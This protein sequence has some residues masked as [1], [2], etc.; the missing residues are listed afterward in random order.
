MRAISLMILVLA[1]SMS[2]LSLGQGTTNATEPQYQLRAGDTLMLDFRLSPELNQTVIVDRDGSISLQIIGRV[3]VSGLTLDRA[4]ALILEKESTHLVRPE[5]NLSLTDF[6]HFYVVVAGEVY[7]P[8]K[9]EI[10]E[11]MTALQAIMLSGGVKNTGSQTQVLLYRKVNSE[12]AEVHP[13]NLRIRKTVELEH[14]MPLMPGDL[15][16]VRRSKVESVTRYTRI[17]GLNYN[18]VPQAY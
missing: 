15:I 11:D 9:L 3:Q 5:L 13:L 17:V 10:R 7:L 2:R 14:D 18:I 8:Q 6:Q 12:Y 16:L 1:L 4:K